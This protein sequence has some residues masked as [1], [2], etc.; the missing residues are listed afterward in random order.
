MENVFLTKADVNYVVFDHYDA[1][2]FIL[3]T[4]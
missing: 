4:Y 3:C 2:W 1:V